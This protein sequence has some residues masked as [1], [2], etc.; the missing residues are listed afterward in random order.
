MQS[1]FGPFWYL[2]WRICRRTWRGS[3]SVPSSLAWSW[4][5]RQTYCAACC[6]TLPRRPL[7]HRRPRR[8]LPSRLRGRPRLLRRRRAASR[9]CSSAS[10]SCP[11]A[12]GGRWPRWLGSLRLQSSTA[13]SLMERQGYPLARVARRRGMLAVAAT[14]WSP[15]HKRVEAA[16]CTAGFEHRSQSP[17]TSTRPPSSSGRPRGGRR[18]VRGPSSSWR[19]SHTSSCARS[20]RMSCGTQ[21]ARAT[22]THTSVGA[23]RLGLP[24]SRR[25]RSQVFRSPT[26]RSYRTTI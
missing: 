24:R 22:A 4:I 13:E 1:H 25:P 14:L 18:G 19:I 9:R 8:R 12:V 3:C 6:P 16:R 2:L 15:R 21:S 26:R 5:S 7:R 10:R 11:P 20:P 17:S 23:S